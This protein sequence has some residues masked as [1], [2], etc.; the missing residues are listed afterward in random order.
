MTWGGTSCLV[1]TVRSQ[2][3]LTLHLGAMCSFEG[4]ESHTL[5]DLFDLV[6]CSLGCVYT[7]IDH[8]YNLFL[9]IEQEPTFFNIK[10]TAF[11]FALSGEV[12]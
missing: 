11:N 3:R 10:S 7:N 12:V 5:V 8:P 9:F 6:P 2:G 4:G 1:L